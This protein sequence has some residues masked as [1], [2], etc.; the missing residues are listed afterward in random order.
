MTENEI[1]NLIIAAAIEVHR[2]LG[3]PGL[4]ESVYSE[5]LS[6]ELKQAGIAFE[7]EVMVPVSYKGTTIPMGFRADIVIETVIILEIKT[8]TAFVPAHESQILT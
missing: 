8:V 4:L 5:C 7:S 1:S 6:L 2:T 3:G